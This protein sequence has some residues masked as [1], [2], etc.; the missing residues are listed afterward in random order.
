[1]DEDILENSSI[2]IIMGLRNGEPVAELLLDEEQAKNP[3]VVAADFLKL[4][5]YLAGNTLANHAKAQ[6][7]EMCE[8]LSLDCY[9]IFKKK[10]ENVINKNI[11]R[12][13]K[14]FINPLD[15]FRRG[16]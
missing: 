10:T 8:N 3:S 14:P 7:K 15:V 5:A 11:A 1:M 9:E 6:F 2:T 13:M 16:K 12:E 4:Y